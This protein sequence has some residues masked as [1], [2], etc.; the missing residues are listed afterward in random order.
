MAN[1]NIDW[2]AIRPLNGSRADGFEELCAQLARAECPLDARFERKGTPD[3]GV[4]CCATLADDGEWGWQAKYFDTLADSQWSQLDESVKHALEKH[5]NLRTYFVCTPLDRADGRIDGRRSAK[6]RWDDH[7][8]KWL[9]WASDRSMAVEFIYWGSHELLERLAKPVHVGRVRFWFDVRGLDPAWF[10]ARLDEALRTAGPRYTPEIHVDLPIAGELQAFGREEGFFDRI[11][12]KAR[13]I[14]R[15][16][17]L[18]EYSTSKASQ[19]LSKISM[20]DFISRVKSILSD[21]STLRVQINGPL[22]FQRIADDLSAAGVLAANILRRLSKVEQQCRQSTD[23]ARKT[24]GYSDSPLREL[25]YHLR[26]FSN[27]LRDAAEALAHAQEVAGPNLM[28]LAGAAGTGKTHLLCDAA[29]ERIKAGRPTILLMG[30]RFVTAEEPWTQALQQLDLPGLSA[31]EFVGAL[32]AATQ[33]AGY[34]TLVMIDAINEGAGRN[35]WPGHLPAFL[36]HLERS[37]WISV[38]LSV[39]SSYE[40]IVIPEQVR[41]RAVR[42]VH[43]GFAEHE[44]DAT[45]TFFVHYGLELPSTPLLAPEFRNPLF[46]KTLCRGLNAAGER[47]LPRGFQGISHVFD[48]YLSAINGRLASALS[49]NPKAQLVRQALTAFA[50]ELVQSGER[51]F[52][53]NKAQALVNAYLPGRDFD[54]SLHQGLVSE[55]LLVEEAVPVKNGGRDEVVFIAYDRFADHLIAKTLLDT[56]LDSA[57]PK[58]AFAAGGPLAFLSDDRRYV[59]PGLLEAIC[60]Q[61]PERTGHELTTL[62]PKITHR[63]G[64]GD[65]FRQSLI[66]RA[67]TAISEDTKEVVNALIRT[68]PDWHDTLD[69]LLTVASLPEHPLNAELL[70]Q[71]LR[72]KSMPERD[73]DWS[74]YLHYARG[75][76]TAVDRLVDWASS[77]TPASPIDEGSLDLCGIALAW[78]LTTSNRFLRDHATKALVN[79]FTGRLLAL[80]RLIERFADVD[81]PYVTERVYAVAYAV[82]TRSCDPVAVGVVAKSVYARVFADGAPPAHILLRD[83]ARGVVERA[84][85]LGGEIEIDEQL[86]RPPYQSKW[87]AIPTEDEIKPYLPEWLGGSKENTRREWARYHIWSSVMD[88]DFARYVIG[89]NSG[90]TNWLSLLLDE[91][92]WQSPDDLLKNLRGRF[93]QDETAAWEQYEASDRSVIRVSLNIRLDDLLTTNLSGDD[94]SDGVIHAQHEPK[95]TDPALE[96]AE[97]KREA[98]LRALLSIV[99]PEHC[100]EL[101]QL[102]IARASKA[103]PPRFDLKIIQRYVLWRVF[104]LGWT[105]KRFGQFDRDAVGYRDRE[106]TK[107]ERIGKKYQWI[108]YH[109]ITALIADHYQYREEYRESGGDHVYHGPWQE[110][111]RDLDPSCTLR[112]TRGGSGRDGHAPSWWG[113][114]SYENWAAPADPREWTMR[115]DDLP[116]LKSLLSVVRP[117]DGSRWLNL[118]G[119]FRWRRSPPVDQEPYEG[120]QRDIWYITTGY[121]IRRPDADAFMRWAEG[122]SFWG[123]WMPEPPELYRMFLGEH[124]WSPASRYFRQP[125]FSDRGWSRPGNDCPVDVL[126]AALEYLCEGRG[127]DCSIDEGFTLRLPAADLVSG[128]DLRWSGT[129]ADFLD[130]DGRLAALDPTAR[131][132]GPDALLIRQDSLDEFLARENLTVCWAVIGE[133]RVLGPDRHHRS[134]PSLELSGAYA[135]H[136]DGP[137]G[138]LNSTL[139]SRNPSD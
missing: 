9:G 105:T 77:V 52:S 103:R 1:I 49:F 102:L 43:H 56:H 99:K 112:S 126:V 44:Y 35:I 42:L 138:F 91:P 11:K 119:Y 47:R 88:D 135:L 39:R 127:F 29:Q 133:K 8:K 26:S 107:A 108:A 31:E 117:D 27:E 17:T 21:L 74:L 38:L 76:H 87:P 68:D 116:P 7:V 24:S 96:T 139:D 45:K 23:G 6:E 120:E 13:E 63:W 10:K 111:L 32:E 71:I 114:A 115:S 113:M 70:D 60:I 20:S 106:A 80:E 94:I 19:D 124:G 122:V 59:E 110:H 82:V 134:Y 101:E 118:Q 30:Q 69:V 92:S 37:A 62:S 2:K 46:L 97:Q 93:S 4:E 125:Y 132:A 28:L 61:V 136:G 109:E 22:P 3:A 55:G 58:A 36:A 85:C 64:I 75:A 129:D 78:M 89:T 34:R 48:L 90:F 95:T 137:A 54:H 79:L 104:D 121:L 67:P 72:Q 83:Y 81:D 40:D 57:D 130:K 128:L 100:S 98:S 73:V 123:R 16:L 131:G 84:L 66:W 14:R 51:W 18:V 5:P 33:A 65:S 86:I 25:Q 50:S 12:A 15:K 41:S 53:L